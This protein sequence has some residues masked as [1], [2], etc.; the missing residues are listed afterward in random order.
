MPVSQRRQPE[1]FV[2]PGVFLIADA[3][4]GRFKQPHNRRQHFLFRQVR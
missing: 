1:R 4:Q 3:Y 2:L